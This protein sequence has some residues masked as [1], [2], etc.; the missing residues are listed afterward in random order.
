ML[1][2]HGTRTDWRESQ[3]SDPVRRPETIM[4]VMV[5]VAVVNPN[6]RNISREPPNDTLPRVLFVPPWVRFVPLSVGG[7]LL[8]TDDDPII[9][10]IITQQPYRDF[11]ITWDTTKKTRDTFH[12]SWEAL[13]AID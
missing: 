9:K 7:S 12:P 11:A 3:R 13:L 10:I 6:C 2:V 1:V 8:G 4:A 5:V